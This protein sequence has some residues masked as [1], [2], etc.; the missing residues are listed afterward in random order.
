MKRDEDQKKKE[1]RKINPDPDVPT[2]SQP[3]PRSDPAR[4]TPSAYL[5]WIPVRRSCSATARGRASSYR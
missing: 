5:P 2:I 3:S 4:A 1:G